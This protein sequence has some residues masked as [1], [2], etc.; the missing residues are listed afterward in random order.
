MYDDDDDDD[1]GPLHSINES[2]VHL[3]FVSMILL[4]TDQYLW[5]LGKTT[6]ANELHMCIDELTFKHLIYLEES[7]GSPFQLLCA[8]W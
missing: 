3:S 5:N 7:E 2:S 4:Q 6:G 8:L 1:E